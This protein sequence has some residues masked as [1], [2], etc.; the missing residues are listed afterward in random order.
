MAIALAT[1]PG[2]VAW[3]NPDRG[4]YFI[5]TLTT[6][7]QQQA[8]EHHFA[9]MITEVIRRMNQAVMGGTRK[10]ICQVQSTLDKHVYLLPY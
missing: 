8:H 1:Y 9:D 3:R 10:Q 4:S 7:F 2:Y 5:Q 6:V